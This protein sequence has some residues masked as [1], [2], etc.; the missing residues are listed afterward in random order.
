LSESQQTENILARKG[1]RVEQGRGLRGAVAGYKRQ[2]VSIGI[3]V[4]CEK[5]NLDRIWLTG[6]DG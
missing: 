6:C 2:L 3:I 1:R 5:M 4:R